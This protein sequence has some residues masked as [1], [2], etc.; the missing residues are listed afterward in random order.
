MDSWRK[1]RAGDRLWNV[2]WWGVRPQ[3]LSSRQ[4]GASSLIPKSWGSP[5]YSYIHHIQPPLKTKIIR[6]II[7]GESLSEQLSICH[8]V[9][10]QKIFKV[11]S[12]IS[13]LWIHSSSKLCQSNKSGSFEVWVWRLAASLGKSSVALWRKTLDC[14]L[15]L[16]PVRPRMERAVRH[17]LDTPGLVFTTLRNK[18]Q[19]N[20][21]GLGDLYKER[22]CVFFVSVIY[23]ILDERWFNW[24]LWRTTLR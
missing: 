11:S 10:S 13:I 3:T 22:R 16:G 20:W 4:L 2:V 6:N 17:H 24:S 23:L 21:A 14:S 1:K 8:W 7:M 15:M 19:K 12:R 9:S 18:K 5:Q